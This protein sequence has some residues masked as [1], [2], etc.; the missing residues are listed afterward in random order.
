M[1]P[2]QLRTS[3]LC[4]ALALGPMLAAQ[5]ATPGTPAPGGQTTQ[6]DQSAPKS[7]PPDTKAPRVAPQ[8]GGQPSGTT[9][10]S[11]SNPNRADAYYHFALA[12]LDEEMVAIYQR[13]EFANKAI[14]EYK[15]ALAD[16]P[17]S[18][19]LNAGLAELYFHTNRIHDAVTEAQ[20]VIARDP[21]NVDAHKLLGGIYLQLLGDTQSG[22]QSQTMLKDAIGQYQEIVRLAPKDWEAHLLL[23]RLHMLNKEFAPAEQEFKEVLKQRPTNEDAISYLTYLYNEEGDNTRA[24]KLVEGIP[25]AQ[26]TAKLQ[27]AL[28]FTYQQQHQY[29]KAVAAYQKAVAA[30]PENL[31]AQRALAQN[32]YSDSQYQAALT[33]EKK[34]AEAD[35][36]DAQTLLRMAEIER[37]LG[38][39]DTAYQTLKKAEVLVPD[40]QEVPY[41]EAV[42]LDA[43]GRPDDAARLLESLVQKTDGRTL[44][45]GEKNNRAIFIERLGN[46]YKA[47]NKTQQAVDTYRKLL[48]LGKEQAERGW[49]DIIDAYR[50]ARMFP[51]ATAAAEES[52]KSM[53]DDKGMKLTLASQLA[54]T[55]KLDEGVKLAESMLGKGEDREVYIALSQIYS[56]ARNFTQAKE[57]LD[58]A[59]ALS[60]KPDEKDY[61]NFLYGALYERQKK[62]DV[63][64]GYFRKALASAPGNAM[65]LNYFGYMLAERGTHLEEAL[66]LIK[67][68]VDQDPQNGAYLDSLG[69]IYYRLGRY[70]LAEQY[71]RRAVEKLSND[72]SVHSHLGDV[73]AKTGRLDMAAAQWKRAVEEYAKALPGDNDPSEI[74]ETQKQLDDARVKLAKQQ[75]ALKPQQ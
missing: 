15:L 40:S 24:A 61:L 43:Q 28:G 45:A 75:S 65:I 26:R 11:A 29:K 51:Q 5:Q 4:L 18:G 55:G 50:D 14:E 9:P 44:T 10:A 74:A 47:Q 42:I 2:T 56:R 16:D 17:S 1:I 57:V 54:D 37:R 6:P 48:D 66:N 41:N 63:A 20:Q 31:D 67:Q 30:D 22:A 23:G 19:Y 73:F 52:V 68:A 13:P 25:E 39:Y 60:T 33:E 27:S 59:D 49:G 34:V 70:D 36:Q 32:L 38:E 21:D 62:Y 35:P 3:L 46:I 53:P 12:H 7:I 64:E 72:G 69:Y 8:P 58:K 71:L